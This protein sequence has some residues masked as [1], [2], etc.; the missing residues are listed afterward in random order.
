MKVVNL[1]KGDKTECQ[2]LSLVHVSTSNYNEWTLSKELSTMYG[3]Y[4]CL[5]IFVTLE[6][7]PSKKTKYNSLLE[8]E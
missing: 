8:K 2:H 1:I 4:I 3:E 6:R 5:M 7:V